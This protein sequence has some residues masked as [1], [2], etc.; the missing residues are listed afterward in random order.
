MKT[1]KETLLALKKELAL[2]GKQ[3]GLAQAKSAREGPVTIALLDKKNKVM[4]DMSLSCDRNGSR[5]R[6]IIDGSTLFA[7]D[8]KSPGPPTSHSITPTSDRL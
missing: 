8:V 3:L 2:V 1:K 6:A 5:W 4:L 7:R